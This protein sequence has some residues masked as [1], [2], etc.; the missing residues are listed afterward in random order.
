MK[1][2]WMGNIILPAIAEKESLPPVYIVGWLVG[3]SRRLTQLPDAA[4]T[5]VFDA[6]KA[7]TGEVDG[8]RY[9]G[10]VNPHAPT[11]RCG[12]AYTRQLEEILRKEQ[13][14]VIHL[15]GTEN[16]HTLAM[17]D[18]AEHLGMRERIVISIQGL[19]SIYAEHYRAYLPEHVCHGHTLK[20]CV[21]GNIVRQEAIYRRVGQYEQE[22]LRRVQHV[23]GRTDWDAACMAELAPQ[24]AYH[25]NNETLRDEFYTGE[26]SLDSCEPHSIF[27]S[28]AHVP[29][30]GAAS[31][32]AGAGD[33]P[34]ALSR[35]QALCGAQGLWTHSAA[36]AQCL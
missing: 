19:L 22:A 23:I 25:F 2:M 15:W 27:C 24:A 21:K 5:Y 10:L 3:L 35:C 29:P 16:Q 20:D 32:I 11:Q 7:L 28:Q 33:C 4:L 30:Q 1:V 14:D 8:Y 26:W 6:P 17:V 36:C 13:P 12:E 18:A 31:A 34:Q 9:Y